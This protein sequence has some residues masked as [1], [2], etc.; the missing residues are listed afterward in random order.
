[1]LSHTFCH[2]LPDTWYVM[3]VMLTAGGAFSWY[4]DEMAKELK[5]AKREGYFSV[6]TAMK[7][8][9]QGD[10]RDRGVA[11]WPEPAGCSRASAGIPGLKRPSS[12]SRA[13][14]IR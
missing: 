4:R 7:L 11:H 5:K 3:G 14:L 6:M 10:E 13:I 12:L 1:M 8:L 2:V 9:A